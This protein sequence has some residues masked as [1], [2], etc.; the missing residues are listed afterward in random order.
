MVAHPGATACVNRLRPLNQPKPIK[1]QEDKNGDPI[2]IVHRG[3]RIA[4]EGIK[5][6]WRID[7]EW[8]RK[9]IS[10][11]YYQIVLK[12]GRIFTV[13]LDLL[14]GG[15]FSQSAAAPA[16]RRGNLDVFVGHTTRATR[17]G[18]AGRYIVGAD[19]PGIDSY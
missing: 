13:F 19:G 4:V 6:R 1:V 16:S 2:A 10:R 17:D 18:A 3:R 15:W 7:D 9:E 11:L 14:G 8:W 12:D 5:D